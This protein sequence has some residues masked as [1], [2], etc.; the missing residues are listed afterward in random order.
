[1]RPAR[2]RVLYGYLG[3]NKLMVQTTKSY[4]FNVPNYTEMMD[5]LIRWGFPITNGDTRAVAR[6]PLSSISENQDEIDVDVACK[7]GGRR[8]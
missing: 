6:P 7:E 2:A 1:M 5:A 4:D 8:K 3:N